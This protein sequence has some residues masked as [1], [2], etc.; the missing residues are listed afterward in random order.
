MRDEQEKKQ[1]SLMRGALV[2]A[3][4]GALGVSGVMHLHREKFSA[5]WHPCRLCV[6]A[7]W[8]PC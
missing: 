6:I 7:P 8:V 1:V 5:N 2:G 4:A 3:G